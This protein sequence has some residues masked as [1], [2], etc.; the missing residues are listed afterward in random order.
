MSGRYHVSN[1]TWFTSSIALHWTQDP[2]TSG[3]CTLQATLSGLSDRGDSAK[4]DSRALV[5]VKPSSDQRQAIANAQTLRRLLAT[6]RAL[7]GEHPQPTC[8]PVSICDVRSHALCSWGFAT[9]DRVAS[10]HR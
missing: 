2:R 8:S 3:T 6:Q 4:A 10:L 5:E 7:T 9:A 1:N